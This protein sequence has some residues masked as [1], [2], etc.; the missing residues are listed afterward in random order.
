MPDSPQ[1]QTNPSGAA[2]AIASFAF[3][4]V[5]FILTTFIT[6]RTDPTAALYLLWTL[7]LLQACALGLSF[8]CFCRAFQRRYKDRTLCFCLSC[9]SALLALAMMEFGAGVYAAPHH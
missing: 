1:S 9:A 4:F 3:T 5:S 8:I 2:P 6:P 7:E